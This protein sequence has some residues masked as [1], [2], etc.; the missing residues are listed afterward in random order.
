MFVYSYWVIKIKKAASL[1]MKRLYIDNIKI[2]TIY[3]LV[4][5]FAYAVIKHLRFKGVIS[6]PYLEHP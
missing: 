4:L 5:P 6:A 1:F 3:N 2:D